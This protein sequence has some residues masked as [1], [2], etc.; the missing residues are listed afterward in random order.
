MMMP[1]RL[2]TILNQEHVKYLAVAHVPTYSAQYAAS[3]MHV[4]G[5]DVAKT[6]VLRSG[7]NM[8]L[9][10]LPASYQINLEKL[11]A[12]VGSQVQLVEENECSRLFPDCEPGVFPP[13]GELYGL[14]VYLDKALSEDPEVILSAGTRSE[15]IRMSSTDFVR[16]VKPKIRSFAESPGNRKSVPGHWPAA[17]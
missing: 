14:P 10:V 8:L 16:L 12:V 2:K 11:S 15:A 17:L 3:V 4:R 7:K 1:T 13:F 9:A 5:K 6:V